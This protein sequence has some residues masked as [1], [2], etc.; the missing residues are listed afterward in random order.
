[1]HS[2]TRARTHTHEFVT[3]SITTAVNLVNI[4]ENRQVCNIQHGPTYVLLSSLGRHLCRQPSQ[5]QTV[6]QL[7]T[8]STLVYQRTYARTTVLLNLP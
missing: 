1:M 4:F 5:M 2:H 6:S 8:L 3:S 7:T